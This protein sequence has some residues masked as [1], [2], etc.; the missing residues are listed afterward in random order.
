MTNCV[1][2][3]IASGEIA[4]HLVHQDEM[5][6][7]FLDTHLIRPGHIQV[8]PREHHTYFDDMP[9]AT[10]AHVVQIGQCVAIALK[11]VYGVPRVAFLFTGGDV[12]HAHAH[13]L[14][15]H[16]NTDVTWRRYIAEE[17]LTFQPLPTAPAEE[18]AIIAE[19][20]RSALG[21]ING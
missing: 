16:E 12:S 21:T 2:C 6:V 20:L 3:R 15:M 8:I 1:F 11:R 5:T 7:A 17:H 9:V 10:A 14:P 19:Q 4:A 13:F 18:L